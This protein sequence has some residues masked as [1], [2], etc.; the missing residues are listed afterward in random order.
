MT[1]TRS[2]ARH[3]EKRIPYRNGTQRNRSLMADSDN[4]NLKSRIQRKA[5]LPW[6]QLDDTVVVLDLNSGDFLELNEI[7]CWI[8]KTLDGSRT[9]A[10]HADAL[11]SEYE[12]PIDTARSD[13]IEF[14]G[15]LC[16]KGLADRIA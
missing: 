2:E 11:A 10:E 14:V 12:I 15:E 3:I 4:L 7:G 13:I 16:S 5:G 1:L 8:W 9:L 6:K